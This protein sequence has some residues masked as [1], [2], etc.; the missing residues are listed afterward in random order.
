MDKPQHQPAD[1]RHPQAAPVTKTIKKK[2]KKPNP[3]DYPLPGDIPQELPLAEQYTCEDLKAT[4]EE[5]LQR[6][7][8]I[9]EAN[10]EKV[11]TRNKYRVESGIPERTWRVHWGSFSRMKEAANITVSRAVKN[12]ETYISKH[13]SRDHYRKLSE[14]ARQWGEKYLR[15]SNKRWQTIAVSGDYH[16]IHSDPFALRVWLDTITR[17]QPDIVC[18]LGDVFDN[19]AFSKYVSDLRNWKITE[20]H[21]FV[22]TKILAPTR[23]ACPDAQIDFL[24]GNHCQRLMRMLADQGEQL[25]IFLSEIH[26]MTLSSLLGLDKYCMNLISRSDLGAWTERSQLQEVKKNY[27]KYFEAFVVTHE[28]KDALKMQAPAVS[29]HH[30]RHQSWSF[31]NLTGQYEVHQLGAMCVRS[32]EYTDA[33]NWGVGFALVHIDRLTK[34]TLIE[35]IP[36]GETGCV[37]GGKFYIRQPGEVG[38]I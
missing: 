23:N 37:V 29:G 12:I 19:L 27:A 20:R 11:I 8:E 5:C 9:A 35:Y 7:R 15:P 13:S 10:P 4:K 22:H 26:G 34:H 14:V 25:Q 28:T 1:Q 21:N 3:P 2:N 30:H 36:I 31:R 32:I 6:L 24:V 16:D 17:A 38:L 33:E 18:F